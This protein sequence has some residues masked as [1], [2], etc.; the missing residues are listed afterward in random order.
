M[1]VTASALFDLTGQRAL[2]TGATGGLG[3]AVVEALASHGAQVVASDREAEAC[4]AAAN[5]W[6]AQGLN[7]QA[8][9]AD[10]LDMD[11]VNRLADAM[12]NEHGGVDVVVHN[13]GIQ[14]PAGPLGNVSADDWDAVMAVNLRSAHVLT[15]RLVPAMAGRGG[16]SVVLLSSIA[17]LR[18][19]RSIGL[20][21]LSKAAL[22]QMARN[23]AV[24][25]G[26]SGVRV[27]AIAPGLIRTP[28]ASGL[29]ADATFMERRLALTPLRRV[30]EP[31]EV[32]GVVLMLAGKAGGFITG[33][34]LVV[35][36]GTLI[37]DGN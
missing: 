36:G 25:W 7:V 4:E 9:P 13:A 31:H 24:E 14:G 12:L 19:N 15:S 32:A 8:R 2:V 18:G 26:P 29:M 5:A 3:R 21:G 22:S 23:L 11:D 6:R 35:D 33:Q 1:S 20:Y 37:S 27:N 17:A 34:T 30:G 16:G 10:L 28:L